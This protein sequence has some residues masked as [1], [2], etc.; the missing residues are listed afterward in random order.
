MGAFKVAWA[1]DAPIPWRANACAR[2]ATVHVGGTLEEIAASERDAWTGRVSERPFVLL[3]Q[4]SL[5]DPSRAPAGKHTVWA[6]C[7][8]PNGSLVNMTQAILAQIERFA[9]GVRDLIIGTSERGPAAG[10]AENPNYV[11]GA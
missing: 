9:P 3:V 7:H 11:G 2:A 6:Y 1:L 8:V 10:E 5:F 4:P